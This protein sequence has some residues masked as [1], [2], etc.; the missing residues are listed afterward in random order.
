MRDPHSRLADA[1]GQ[2]ARTINHCLPPNQQ[3]PGRHPHETPANWVARIE[4]ALLGRRFKTKD[5]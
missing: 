3:I 4:R 1:V 5:D 2:L